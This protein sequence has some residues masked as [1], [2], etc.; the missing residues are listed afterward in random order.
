MLYRIHVNGGNR[1]GSY[2]GFT[3][4]P[5]AAAPSKARDAIPMSSFKRME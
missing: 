2:V 5:E 3:F 4:T 1:G